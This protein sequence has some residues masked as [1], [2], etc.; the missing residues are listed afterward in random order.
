[1]A[2]VT[3]FKRGKIYWMQYRVN[4]HRVRKSLQTTRL[5]I[6]ERK[7]QVQERKI[8]MGEAEGFRGRIKLES[9]WEKYLEY[10]IKAKRPRTVRIDKQVWNEFSNWADKHGIA[11]LDQITVSR[12]E[13]Y[14]VFLL[15]RGLKESSVNISH[16]QVRAMLSYAVHIGYLDSNP[17]K[18]IKAYKI[19]QQAPRFLSKEEIY[20]ILDCAKRHG[21]DAHI[22][23]ALGIYAGFRKG[24]IANSRWEWFDLERRIINLQPCA[25]FIPKN[26]RTRPI[27]IHQELKAVL[28]LYREEEGYLLVSPVAETN[29]KNYER[30]DF[31]RPFN[32]VKKAVGLEWVTAHIL[33][34]TFASQLALAGV[35]LYKIQNWLG[36]SDPKT[37]MIYAH[38]QAQDDEIDLI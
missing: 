23:Y 1:M 31:K 19:V 7:A 11:Y 37:T 33:R 34:H 6:A 27:P 32:A 9:F 29:R 21:R 12:F 18:K 16:R 5:Q 14:R 36:H 3:L 8:L 10:A 2:Q 35:S 38:L 26:H 20:R 4:G 22:I 30:Y 25:G 13:E 28:E 24:E 17:L 15:D